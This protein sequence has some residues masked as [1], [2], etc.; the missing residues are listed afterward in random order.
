MDIT[1]DLKIDDKPNAYIY[2]RDDL[3]DTRDIFIVWFARLSK[4]KFK[5]PSNNLLKRLA[6]VVSHVD[7]I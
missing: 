1:M 7:P 4:L 2:K 3:I 5:H 6:N